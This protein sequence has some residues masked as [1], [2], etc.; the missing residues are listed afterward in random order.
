TAAQNSGCNAVFP[1][2]EGR[3][4][5]TLPL[6]TQR[7][8]GR[9]DLLY[10]LHRFHGPCS[11]DDTGQSR[12]A[13]RRKPGRSVTGRKNESGAAGIRLEKRKTPVET[14]SPASAT[15]ELCTVFEQN[16]RFPPLPNPASPPY[17]LSSASYSQ[18]RRLACIYA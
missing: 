15:T 4:R 7:E 9:W 3:N 5:I 14:A 1:C 10:L 13:C 11:R 18:V 17:S 12:E 16:V 8:S 6:S 2:T